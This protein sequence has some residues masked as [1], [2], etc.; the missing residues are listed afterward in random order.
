MR[1]LMTYAT[2]ALCLAREDEVG[3]EVFERKITVGFRC[4]KD[5]TG[6][7]SKVNKL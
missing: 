4:Q 3:L 1:S 7:T 2:E 6:G 5:G